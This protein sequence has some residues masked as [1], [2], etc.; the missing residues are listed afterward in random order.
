LVPFLVPLMVALDGAARLPWCY[1]HV[2]QDEGGPNYLLARGV[3]S[4][5]VEYL[6]GCFRLLMPELMNQGAAHHVILEHRD[7]IGIGH[8]RELMVLS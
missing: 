1:F 7:D 4:G 2:A 8:P 5:N 3:S 6:L